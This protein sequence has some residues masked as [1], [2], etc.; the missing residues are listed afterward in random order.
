MDFVEQAQE[1]FMMTET[2]DKAIRQLNG[3]T[4]GY[5]LV[6]DYIIAFKALVPLLDLMT[7]H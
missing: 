7:M 3:L 6:E 1:F 4:Q 2:W 5:G